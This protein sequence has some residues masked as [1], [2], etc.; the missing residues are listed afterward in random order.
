[1]VLVNV[2]L[3]S[4]ASIALRLRQAVKS[5]LSFTCSGG[6]AYNKQ[7]A[8][9]ASALNKPNQ[10]TV[11]TTRGVVGLMGGLPLKKLRNFGG[12]LGGKLEA[13]GCKTAGDVMALSHSVLSQQFG[14]ERARYLIGHS[15]WSICWWLQ[16]P[17]PDV[18]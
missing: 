14:S 4:G 17:D 18:V 5:D 10:Q 2:N 9:V 1:M 13:M 6:V 16:L 12:K 7:L 15:F 3:F 8:K 11:V